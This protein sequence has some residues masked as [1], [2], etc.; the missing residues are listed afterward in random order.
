[1]KLK[2]AI[3]TVFLTYNK[4]I[5]EKNYFSDMFFLIYK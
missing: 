3:G 4:C 5:V 1:M 2:H